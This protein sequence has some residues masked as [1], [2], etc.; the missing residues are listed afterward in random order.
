M[1]VFSIEFNEFCKTN[2]IIRYGD[3][4]EINVH[5]IYMTYRNAVPCG[6]LLAVSG[7]FIFFF[8]LPTLVGTGGSY[9]FFL[10]YQII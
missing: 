6:S 4:I 8:F 1:K 2:W 9:F 10:S 7:P 5:V 3:Y